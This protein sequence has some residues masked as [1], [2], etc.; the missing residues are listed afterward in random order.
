[1]VHPTDA[2]YHD[3]VKSSRFKTGRISD[4]HTLERA[5]A[6]KL[7]GALALVG[8]L[9]Y[10][11]GLLW[12]GDLPDATTA[13]ALAHVAERPDWHLIHLLAIGGALL[14]VGA[15]AAVAHALPAG[16][17]RL[18]ARLAVLAI[19]VGAAVFI[20]HYSIDGYRLKHIADAWRAAT[21]AERE[22][23]LRVAQ[24]L[25]GI[26]GGTFR[27]YIM[28]LYGLP[29]ILLGLAIARSAL[30]PAWFGWV[31][32]VAGSG[33][34]VTGAVQFL[35]GNL[36]PFPVLFGACVIPLN[37]WLAALGVLTWRRGATGD[38]SRQALQESGAA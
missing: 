35:G 6:R 18:L 38:G 30:Y 9:V 24:T 14:W 8:A 34:L 23:L 21:G 29:F 37:I 7:G 19:A 5:A 11:A 26:L 22:A 2:G 17:G 10:L 3:P 13:M 4:A 28:C 31:A 15:F 16:V 33:A 25:L 27:S 20:V 32:V 12:H 1:M 36:I